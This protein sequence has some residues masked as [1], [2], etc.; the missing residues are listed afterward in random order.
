MLTVEVEEVIDCTCEDVLEMV[1]DIERYAQVDHKIHPVLW[2]RRDGDVVTFACRPKLAGLRQPKVIQ[3]VQLTPG[4][5]IDIG[6]TPLPENRIAHAV[7][8]FQASFRTC[9]ADRGTRVVRTLTFQFAPW[10]RWVLEPL[11]AA[12]LER[13]VRDELRRAKDYLERTG[14]RG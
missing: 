14:P 1:M 2:S 7:A 8:K 6:L 11:F 4:R 5:S 12:R 3:Y 10:L 13:E 9:E